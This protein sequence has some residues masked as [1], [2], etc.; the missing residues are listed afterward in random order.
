MCEDLL[1][2]PQNFEGHLRLGENFLLDGKT[3]EAISHFEAAYDEKDSLVANQW[4]VE[5]LSQENRYQEALKIANEKRRDYLIDARLLDKYL[6]LL[7]GTQQLITC[8]IIA[9]SYLKEAEKIA[10]IEQRVAEIEKF[11]STYQSQQLAEKI[12]RLSSMQPKSYELNQF[13]TELET[14]PLVSY[15]LLTKNIL[16]DSRYP[17]L[18]RTLLLEKLV[19]L[20]VDQEVLIFDFEGKQHQVVPSQLKPVREQQVFLNAIKYLQDFLADGTDEQLTQLTHEQQLYFNCLYPFAD[21]WIKD[22]ERWV[23]TCLSPYQEI[24]AVPLKQR[25][26]S[27]GQTEIMLLEK[28]KKSLTESFAGG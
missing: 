16:G 12:E 19:Y 21:R 24:L 27:E 28:L 3:T 22:E 23:Q 20:K 15:L 18:L 1:N 6:E 14:L 17:L 2:F 25:P 4:L 5:A 13:L 11:L 9:L 26:T 10:A 7:L 8:R